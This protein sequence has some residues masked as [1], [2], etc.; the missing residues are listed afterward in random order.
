MSHRTK[1][2]AEEIETR[3]PS[4]DDGG[5]ARA[6]GATLLMMAG[7]LLEDEPV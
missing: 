7:E 5:I 6:D 3:C 2:P 1:I 4:D